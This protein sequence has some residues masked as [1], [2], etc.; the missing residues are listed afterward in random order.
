MSDEVLLVDTPI[1]FALQ[2]IE[3]AAIAE[4]NKILPSE[5]ARRQLTLARAYIDR[6]EELRVARNMITALSKDLAIYR[7]MAGC[8]TPVNQVL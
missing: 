4:K 1:G 5:P 2:V 8:A 3:D 6:V 7:E